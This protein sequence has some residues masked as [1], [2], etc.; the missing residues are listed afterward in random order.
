MLSFENA[1]CARDEKKK[2]KIYIITYRNITVFYR[3][4]NRDVLFETS[5]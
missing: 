5:S 4:Y 1:A 3:R 2:R